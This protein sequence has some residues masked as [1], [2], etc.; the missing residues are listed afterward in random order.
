MWMIY[1]IGDG[2]FLSQILNSI[3]M[4]T[5]SGDFVQLVKVGFLIGAIILAFQGIMNG[6]KGIDFSQLFLSWIIFA[7]VFGPTA[8]VAIEDV[9]AKEVRV[10]DNVP[11]GVAA[12]GSMISKIGIGITRLFEQAFATPAMTDYGF[13]SSLEMLN[14]VRAQFLNERGLLNANQIANSDMVRSWHNYIKECTLVGVDI[15]EIA[16]LDVMKS[17]DPLSALKFDSSIYGTE[18]I[19]DNKVTHLD[20]TE[21]Y[22]QLSQLTQSD[23]IPK[24]VTLIK[25]KISASLVEGNEYLLRD[26]LNQLG[27]EA[28]STQA[29]MAAAVLLPIY[30][31]A[32]ITKYQDNQSF[33]AASMVNQAILQRN[34]Q[35]A[36]EQT[37]FQNIVRPMMTFF[38]G[39]IYAITPM[40]AFVIALGALG[41]RMVG[42]YLLI[43][44]WIQLWMPLLAIINLYIHLTIQSQLN[45]LSS[46]GDL[47]ISSFSGLQTLDGMLQSWLAT[48]GMLASSVPAIALM[49]VYGSSIT[50]THL[51][52]RLQN[53]DTIDEKLL[54]PDINQMSAVTQTSPLYETSELSGMAKVGSSN[55]IQSFSLANATSQVNS[56]AKEQLR[57]ASEQFSNN[58]GY[59]MSEGYGK[60]ISFESLSSIGQSMR[61]SQSESSDMVNRITQDYQTH[62]GFSDDKTEAVRGLITGVLTGGLSVGKS[63]IS[64]THQPQNETTPLN[65]IMSFGGTKLGASASGDLSLQGQSAHSLEQAESMQKMH[66]E[67]MSLSENETIKS[68]FMQAL[69]R[70]MSN[71][72]KTGISQVAGQHYESKLVKSANHMQSATDKLSHVTQDQLSLTTQ[73]QTDGRIITQMA[74]KSPATMRYIQNY[75]TAHPQAAAR[76]R[77]NLPLYRSLLTDGNQAYVAAALDALAT[78]QVGENGENDNDNQ[79]LMKVIGMATQTSIPEINQ[80]A[81]NHKAHANLDGSKTQMSVLSALN[82]K[83]V[84]KLDLAQLYQSQSD[85]FTELEQHQP[86]QIQSAQQANNKH[87]HNNHKIYQQAND[88]SAYQGLAKQLMQDNMS[89]HGVAQFIGTLQNIHKGMNFA[90]DASTGILSYLTDD[91]D[92]Y[93]ANASANPTETGLLHNAVLASEATFAGFKASAQAGLVS[94]NPLSAFA[95]AYDMSPH[96]KEDNINWGTK[97]EAILAGMQTASSQQKLAQFLSNNHQHFK[98][99]AF[100]EGISMGLTPLQSEIFAVTFTENLADQNFDASDKDTWPATLQTLRQ[101]MLLDHKPIE[102]VIP[103]DFVDKQI[104]KIGQASM[105]GAYAR[106]DLMKVRALNQI[107][108]RND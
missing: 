107:K 30:E 40:M 6:A 33:T 9:Y 14:Q 96:A 43:L 101:Q 28:I 84:P 69:S 61:S 81:F 83:S 19:I 26:A 105:L 95:Q 32:V 35:W 46:K 47:Q 77:D 29:F 5:G 25:T 7:M 56:H 71:N 31:Q 80:A 34:T 57:Q 98:T 85:A 48:G 74:A 86:Q 15:G 2:H 38:E 73:K 106:H 76:L 49:L 1:S 17:A 102:G 11:L 51:A 62:Y 37:L 36:A 70:D 93:L 12:T 72:T 94:S 41:L 44:L 50:A 64:N 89:P 75:M 65:K 104:A 88:N 68:D 54:T 39:F 23:M 66:G 59:A 90:S 45:L 8:R 18:I 4:L 58:L 16:L 24:L 20:C 27:Q 13:V 78:G 52:G 22:H 82:Q 103:E 60:N 63:G 55:L 87:V 42:K 91:Y 67:L 21:A 53:S 100:D 99:A 108:D 10:V 79:A 3:A 92:S 97:V